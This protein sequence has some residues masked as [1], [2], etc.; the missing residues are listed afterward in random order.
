[1][2][3]LTPSDIEQLIN[4]YLSVYLNPRTTNEVFGN[5]TVFFQK[6][7]NDFKNRRF[8]DEVEINWYLS[9]DIFGR[10]RLNEVIELFFKE[11]NTIFK[12]RSDDIDE[13]IVSLL[14]AFYFPYQGFCCPS[15]FIHQKAFAFFQLSF[16]NKNSID[17]DKMRSY[18]IR[19]LFY[20]AHFGDNSHLFK[21]QDGV[22]YFKKFLIRDELVK[23]L[24]HPLSFVAKTVIHYCLLMM[25]FMENGLENPLKID[26][27]FYDL[28]HYTY[29]LSKDKK[30]YHLKNDIGHL[31]TLYCLPKTTS[32]DFIN[33]QFLLNFMLK[34]HQAPFYI[35]KYTQNKTVLKNI[36]N[37]MN[38]LEGFYI[39]RKKND[40]NKNC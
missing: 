20:N 35:K 27:E 39:L 17:N 37:D 9:F 29:F 8:N 3:N 24:D 4:G 12:N 10:F 30:P 14:V 25:D 6:Y 13:I 38:D 2:T 16:N 19:S 26:D 15:N 31:N 32:G 7:A 23:L 40:K 11:L 21:L 36:F 33:K 22:L 18:D 28:S 5:Q 1:M 34:N